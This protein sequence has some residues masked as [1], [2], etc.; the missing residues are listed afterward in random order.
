MKDSA[1]QIEEE[2]EKTKNSMHKHKLDLARMKDQI[3]RMD[4]KDPK[5]VSIIFMSPFEDVGVY[6]FA[7]YCYATREDTVI[8]AHS[9]K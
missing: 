2:L 1:T 8:K 9:M 6:C 4:N 5:Y 7:Q 3:S